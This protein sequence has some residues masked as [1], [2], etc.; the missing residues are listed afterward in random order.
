MRVLPF[1]VDHPESDIFVRRASSEVKQHCVV[2]PRFLDNLIRWR[3]GFIDEIGVED[4]KLVSLNDLWW[5]VVRTT[6]A[7]Q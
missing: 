7:H 4:V 1:A 5:G 6:Q 3:L 2:V